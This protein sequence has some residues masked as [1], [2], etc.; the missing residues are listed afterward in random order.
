MALFGNAHQGSTYDDE[1]YTFKKDWERIEQYIPKDKV[2]WEAFSNGQFEG[3][4]YLTSICQEVKCNTGDFFQNNYGEVIITNPPFSIKRKVLQRLKELNKPFICI[5]PTLSLQTKYMKDIFGDELQ[6]I[7][8][9]KK[10]FFYKWIN[11]EKV[12]YNKLSYYCCYIC[13]K[14][15]L[16]QDMILLN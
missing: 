16:P 3:V 11:G 5:L 10:M 1:F 13:W 15:E 9:T 2:V 7:F 6:V 14:M 12:T 8:P 4:E